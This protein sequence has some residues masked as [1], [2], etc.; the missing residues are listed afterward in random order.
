[1]VA[2]TPVQVLRDNIADTGSVPA[3]SD[4]ELS[5]LLSEAGGVEPR[6]RL[7][8]LLPL[9]TEAAGHTDYSTGT[10]SESASQA[11][12]QLQA[13]MAQAQSEVAA[14]DAAAQATQQAG[15]ASTVAVAVQWVF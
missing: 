1:M 5:A 15:I 6:A 3:W 9:W 11:F 14:L 13:L 4:P 10:V 8:A 7:A 2:R 12:K